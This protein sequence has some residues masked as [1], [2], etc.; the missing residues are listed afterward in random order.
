MFAIA[1]P[2]APINLG[3]DPQRLPNMMIGYDP[4]PSRHAAWPRLSSAFS[5]VRILWSR[6]TPIRGEPQTEAASFWASVFPLLEMR[7]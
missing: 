2:A 5:V 7:G 4:A 3:G 6:P 1:A